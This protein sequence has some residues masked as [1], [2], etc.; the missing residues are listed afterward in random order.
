MIESR[1]AEYNR[2]VFLSS[3]SA[4]TPDRWSGSSSSLITNEM[5]TFLLAKAWLW[6]WPWECPEDGRTPAAILHVFCQLLFSFPGPLLPVPDAGF[7]RA[8]MFPARRQKNEFLIPRWYPTLI[9]HVGEF[10]PRPHSSQ[11]RLGNIYIFFLPY[12]CDFLS[13]YGEDGDRSD[14]VWRVLRVHWGSFY[15]MVS[16]QMPNHF[17]RGRRH[18]RFLNSCTSEI[19]DLPSTYSFSCKL[20]KA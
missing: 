20:H 14:K 11:G 4:L 9:S 8:P 12:P 6:G 3:W 18:Y 13:N 19:K 1:P 17:A 10:Q 5:V 15:L 2:P 16:S 7:A